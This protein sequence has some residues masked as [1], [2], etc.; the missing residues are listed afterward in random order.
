MSTP[1]YETFARKEPQKQNSILNIL[2][3]GEALVLNIKH[4]LTL[5]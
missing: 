2:G 3:L 1:N 5:L 4:L